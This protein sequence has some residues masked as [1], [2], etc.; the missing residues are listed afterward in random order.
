MFLHDKKV[1]AYLEIKGH[2]YK[3]TYIF[4]LAL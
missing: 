1:C 3:E 4:N 2:D